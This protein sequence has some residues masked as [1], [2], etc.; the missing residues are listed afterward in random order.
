[1]REK[2]LFHRASFIILKNDKNQIYCHLRHKN[3]KWAPHH[4]T[5]CFG[6]VVGEGEN[7]QSNAEKELLEEAGIKAPLKEIST[8]C[9]SEEG[10]NRVWGMIF[11]V[12][13]NGKLKLQEEECEEY[14]LM[15][16]PEIEADMTKNKWA[17]DAAEALK[18]YLIYLQENNLEY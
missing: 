5:V 7:Y 15:T 9:Y 16:I 8:F 10:K 3:K 1:M 13:Y 12:K 4:W 18:S 17:E 6:G 14:K 11:E 2:N